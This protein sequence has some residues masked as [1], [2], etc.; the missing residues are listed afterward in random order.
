VWGGGGTPPTVNKS[1]SDGFL[2]PDLWFTHLRAK[3][4]FPS[5]I[6]EVDPQWADPRGHAEMKAAA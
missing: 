5:R 4:A 2:F 6:R 1:Q 3:L